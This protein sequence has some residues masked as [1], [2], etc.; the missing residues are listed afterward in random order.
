MA[1][2]VFRFWSDV[3]TANLRMAENAI[4][5]G[6]MAAASATVIGHRSVSTDPHELGLMVTEKV[7]AWQQAGSA[8]AGDMARLQRDF[9]QQWQAAGRPMTASTSAGT[10]MA[11]MAARQARML[12]TTA[13]A[14]EKASKPYHSRA[15]ANA[16]RLTA[17]KRRAKRS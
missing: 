14:V 7:E 16:R 2:T 11:G 1:D 4:R 5:L 13:R 17:G 15:G 8:A 10:A 12:G 6:E 9:A 3:W